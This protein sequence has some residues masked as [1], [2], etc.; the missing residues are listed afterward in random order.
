MNTA[1]LTTDNLIKYLIGVSVAMIIISLSVKSF[2]YAFN[3][4]QSPTYWFEYTK[5][6]TKES[7]YL[8]NS[9]DITMLSYSI[10]KQDDLQAVW[11]DSLLCHFNDEK[12]WEFIGSKVSTGMV[13]TADNS[14]IPLSWKLGIKA[15]SIAAVCKVKSGIDVVLG[16]V[17]KRQVIE[18]NEFAIV[19]PSEPATSEANP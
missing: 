7:S 18:S 9:N 12:G 3:V 1:K 5:T 16:D 17:T 8:T 19:E 14:V 6:E 4:L 15:P 11:I 2:N 13:S 10:W